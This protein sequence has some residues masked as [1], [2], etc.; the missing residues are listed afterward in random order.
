MVDDKPRSGKSN[1]P[2]RYPGGKFYARKLIMELLPSDIDYYCEPFVGGGSIYFGQKNKPKALLN[3]LDTDL[4][5][6]YTVIRDH[7]GELITALDGILATKKNHSYYKNEYKPS[8]DIEKALR[9][10]YLNRTSYSGIMKHDNCYWGYGEK[11]SMVPKNWPPHLRQVSDSLQGVKLTSIDFEE[12]I[13]NLPDGT[14]C[15]IDPPYFNADQDKFYTCSFTTEDHIRL[16]DVLER[17]SNRIQFMLTYDNTD[18][19]IQL[20]VDWVDAILDK[21]W[22]Y[23]IARTD[24][25]KEGLKLKDGH[26]GNRDKGKE[27]FILNYCPQPNQS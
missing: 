26:K 1:S 5:N 12:L 15:F 3:D 7:V 25:Q 20:Y 16:R 22:N 17:N 23:T 27:I 14:F 11:Y 6:T 19:V 10:F 4:M 13:D 21:E 18:E 8:N 9:W 24:N 2:F